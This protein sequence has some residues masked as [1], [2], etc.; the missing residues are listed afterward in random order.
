MDKEACFSRNRGA[1][2]PKQ[3]LALSHSR[4]AVFGLGGVGGLA[5]ELLARAGVGYLMAAD[6]DEFEPTNL[7][8]QIHAQKETIGKK[9]A[10]VFEKKAK[11]INGK[12][13]I[14]KISKKLEYA[15]LA[16]F[17]RKLADFK[18]NVIVDT[19]DSI[20]SRVLLAR[21]CKKQGIPYVYAAAAGER[22]MVMLVE[23]KG[24]ESLEKLL[25]LPSANRPDSQ[26]ESTLIH[27]PQCRT[28]WGPATNLVGA[29]AAN[30]A[31]NYLLQ[32]PYPKAPKC[33]MTDAFEEKIV[34]EE[35][36]G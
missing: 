24:K 25:H 1:I 8:R 15:S 31:L 4:I 20:G 21:I 36:L 9:K 10:D 3:Q 5:A 17:E 13:G 32:K 16:Y 11:A 14:K 35:R 28:A 30:V 12:I 22:G 19:M 2:A 23:G 29:L 26:V 33:W 27:Y 34:R 6:F 7:N 18:P